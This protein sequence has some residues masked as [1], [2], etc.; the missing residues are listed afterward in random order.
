[1]KRINDGTAKPR[2]VIIVGM[3][4]EE[5]KAVGLEGGDVKAPSTLFTD[6]NN[7]NVDLAHVTTGHKYNT[8]TPDVLNLLRSRISDDDFLEKILKTHDI[9][10]NDNNLLEVYRNASVLLGRYKKDDVPDE[11]YKIIMGDPQELKNYTVV[12]VSFH[13]LLKKKIEE[14]SEI[15]E[16][17][18]DADMVNISINLETLTEKVLNMKEEKKRIEGTLSATHTT[19]GEHEFKVRAAEAFFADLCNLLN[20]DGHSNP[21]Y[22]LKRVGALLDEKTR[23]QMELDSAVSYAKEIVVDGKRRRVDR[24][25][26]S[27]ER[28]GAN[29]E[30]YLGP[31]LRRV[32]NGRSKF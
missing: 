2:K 28:S 29:F 1:M 20:E 27:V 6:P 12:S 19:S 32:R 30:K 22:V 18:V 10:A 23:L 15:C 11:L 31:A 13:S 9:D 17:S 8:V 16:P 25:G 26:A 24:S 7:L 3:E 21:Q 4:I 5:A 14:I